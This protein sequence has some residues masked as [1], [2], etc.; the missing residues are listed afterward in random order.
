MSS[1]PP[2]AGAT[3]RGFLQSAGALAGTPLV[4][5]SGA[6]AATPVPAEPRPAAP[7]ALTLHVNGK[8]HALKLEPRTTLLDALRDHLGLVGTKKGCDRGQCGACTVLV[9]GRRINAC[10]SLALAHD[11]E[12]IVTIEGLG[13]PG[14]LHPLQAA[15]VAADAFQCGYCTPGQIMSAV[16]CIR[17]GHAGSDE[18][19]REYM[20]GNLCRCGAYPHIVAAVRQA[21]KEL[22]A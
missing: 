9:D 3:R 5:G 1:D 14:A 8:S 11:G 4:A 16:A 18:E 22:S 10:L 6:E 20:A 13:Q 12:Q 15:F 21:A 19:I 17:E 7:V 2:V